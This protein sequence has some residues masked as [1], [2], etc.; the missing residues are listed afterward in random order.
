MAIAFPCFSSHSESKYKPDRTKHTY[1][2]LGC[3][4]GQYGCDRIMQIV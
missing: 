4:C 1:L 3:G 2:L